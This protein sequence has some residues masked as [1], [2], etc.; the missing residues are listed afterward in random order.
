MVSI[1]SRYLPTTS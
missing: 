1:L